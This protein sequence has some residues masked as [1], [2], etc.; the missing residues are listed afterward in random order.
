MVD[1]QTPETGLIVS[2]SSAALSPTDFRGQ[3]SDGERGP[4]R[5]EIRD[6]LAQLKRRIRTYVLL[7]GFA[8]L[9]V[10][11]GGFFWL[12]LLVDWVYFR[13]TAL[14]LPLWIR[15]GIAIAAMALLAVGALVWI[16]LRYFAR[17]R[18]RALAL[19]LERRFP[20][21]GTRL[22]AAVEMSESRSALRCA[23][24]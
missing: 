24:A 7:E 14:E 2:S 20:E 4:L 21:L 10:A 5:P 22:I 12:T 15:E 1:P 23:G 16:V 18:A 13:L 11:V 6:V 8:L 3:P 17:F 9:A 19:V